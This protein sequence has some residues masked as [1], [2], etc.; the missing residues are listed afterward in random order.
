[1]N[2]MFNSAASLFPLLAVEYENG[3][4]LNFSLIGFSIIAA[5]NHML[6]E[7]LPGATHVVKLL[8]SNILFSLINI[9]PA[10]GF[11]ISLLDITPLFVKNKWLIEVGEKLIQIPR[12]IIDFYLIYHIAIDKNYLERALF[13]FI[14][15]GIYFAERQIR[16]SRHERSNFY[17]LHCFEHIGFYIL[18]C[19]VIDCYPFN[20]VGYVKI[21]LCF[22]ACWTSFIFF[23]TYY[24]H[25]NF[26][27]RAPQWL[28][29]DKN[30][31][32]ILDLKIQKNLNQGKIHNY[33]C[34]PWTFH[35]K[36]EIITWNKIEKICE[37]LY[38]K[39]NPDDFDAVIGISTGGAFIGAYMGK[40]LNKPYYVI[41]SKLW[42]GLSFV[43]NSKQAIGFFLGKDINPN[44]DGT[45]P[46]QGQRIL[47][48]D[49]TTYTGITMTKCK[50]YCEETLKCSLVKTLNFW[51][52]K[53]FIP[54]YYLKKKRVPIFWEWG[55][56]MD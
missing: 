16:I 13:I 1:M 48:C 52:H 33:I 32:N 45:P 14:C 27:M 46:V 56:E 28:K 34:K 5:I 42:S 49:D 30:L 21:F 2:E 12:Q 50:K 19:S 39:I 7:N 55:A 25:K 10:I 8:V 37:E 17:F 29:D 36:M 26:E 31:L 23:F 18:I 22:M 53:R 15:K 54:D 40:L 43:N 4:Y 35:L 38:Q 11:T 24:L 6:P 51:I 20:F 41:H 44:I 9:D 47:L 3:L